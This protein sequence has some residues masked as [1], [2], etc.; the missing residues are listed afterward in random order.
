M[1]ELCAKS[2]EYEERRRAMAFHVNSSKSAAACE[3]KTAQSHCTSSYFAIFTDACKV[4]FFITFNNSL[5]VINLTLLRL[6]D[7]V[8]SGNNIRKGTKA[9]CC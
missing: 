8:I 9:L 7:A 5:R 6:L 2:S 4:S 3:S 1:R